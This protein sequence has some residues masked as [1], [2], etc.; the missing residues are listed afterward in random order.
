[1]SKEYDKLIKQENGYEEL[2]RPLLPKIYF[3]SKEAKI[4]DFSAS[5]I[6]VETPKGQ[7]GAVD[8]YLVNNDYGTSN[9]L[10]YSYKAST[11]KID[12]VVPNVGRKQGND[13][14]ELLGD[15]FYNSDLLVIKSEIETQSIKMPLVQFGSIEDVNIS[16]KSVALD[17]KENSGKIRDKKSK[18]EV[19]SLRVTYDMSGDKKNLEFKITEGTGNDKKEYDFTYKEYKNSEIF[20][21]T[22]LLKDKDGK[23][24]DKEKVT[25]EYIRVRL[26]VIEGANSTTRLRV[27]RGFSPSAVLLSNRQV[28][29]RTPSYYTVGKTKVTIINPDGGTASNDF[30]YKNPDSDPTITNILKDGE[31]G[32][33]ETYTQDGIDKTRKIVRVNINGGNTIDILGTDFRK[34]VKINATN[35]KIW[36]N[37][38]W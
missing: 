5:S 25:S 20:F 3:G 4:I 32:K 7:N 27:D 36:K 11:P 19:G 28:S 1:M 33:I 9:K 12:T 17:A 23:S 22:S 6:E 15:S 29:L 13:K 34:P 24:Y 26:D 16:N 18:V 2:V 30:E 10:K 31:E 21:P 38:S 37:R 8:V 14:I 35:K